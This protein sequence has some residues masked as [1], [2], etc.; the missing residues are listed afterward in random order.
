[1][2]RIVQRKGA[3]LR[4]RDHLEDT[5]VDGRIILKLLFKKYEGGGGVNSIDL[6]KNKAGSYSW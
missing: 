4:E 6:A 3:Y 2:A 1:M 5:R